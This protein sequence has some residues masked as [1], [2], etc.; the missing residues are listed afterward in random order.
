ME[1]SVNSSSNGVRVC[2]TGGA[3]FIAFWLVNAV[4]VWI[5]RCFKKLL[6]RGYTVHA[7]L[8]DTGNEEK[9]GLLQRLVPGAVRAAGAVRGRPLRRRHVRA[10]TPPRSRQPSLDAGS[11]SSSP[12][13]SSTTPRAPSTGARRKRLRTR[14]G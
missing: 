7:T 5:F 10:T 14:R 12:R 3:G 8:R 9:A 4:V 11:S 1:E 13:R 2:V 6:D